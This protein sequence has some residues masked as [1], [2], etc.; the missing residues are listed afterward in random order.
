M[1]DKALYAQVHAVF[2]EA[3]ALVPV[4]QGVFLDR[5]CVGCPEVRAEVEELLSQLTEG[6]LFE[7]EAPPDDPMRIVGV[8]I[9]GR[10][11]VDA[12]VA[13]G[14]SSHVY[15][16]WD[17]EREQPVALKL[18]RE[19]FAVE[20]C[21]LGEAFVREGEI[22]AQLSRQTTSV[23]RSLDLGTW[24]SSRGHP[25]TYTVLEWLEGE[26]LE[27]MLS[28]DRRQWTLDEVMRI[29]GPVAEVLGLAHGE[30]IA[31]RDIKPANIFVQSEGKGLKLMDFG[32]AKLAAHYSRGFD[33][34][35]NIA[36][37]FTVNYAAPEQAAAQGAPTGPRTDVYALALTCVEMLAGRP[38]YARA[39]VSTV[40]AQAL[41]TRRR[42]TPRTL[43]VKISGAVEAVFKAALAVDPRA[44]PA[45]A[46]AFWVA[47]DEARR[48]RR[49]WFNR[50]R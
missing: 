1:M 16:G 25:V 35:A 9:D 28:D 17:L 48:D 5:A 34:T 49:R 20:P 41:D 11:R 43:G 27:A 19:S 36:S 45:D 47:L 29:L 8:V 7:M 18:F 46:T 4:E 23:V 39:D 6:E 30:G 3:C 14:G 13:M 21:H 26:T 38:P 24:T 15:R 32:A 12:Y 2:I 42:P 40:L 31:H 50:W 22:L 44:R 37:P 10:Y 33:G